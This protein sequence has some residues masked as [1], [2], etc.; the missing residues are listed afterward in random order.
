[1]HTPA[2]MILMSSP[3]LAAHCRLPLRLGP[4]ADL[5]GPRAFSSRAEPGNVGAEPGECVRE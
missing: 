5:H 4:D 2:A 3:T 1:M